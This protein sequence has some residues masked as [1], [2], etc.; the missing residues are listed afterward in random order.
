MNGGSIKEGAEEREREEFNSAGKSFFSFGTGFSPVQVVGP[1]ATRRSPKRVY[2]FLLG[3]PDGRRRVGAPEQRSLPVWAV[4]GMGLV[5]S[6]SDYVDLVLDF[7]VRAAHVSA[8][9]PTPSAVK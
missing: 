4:I 8:P 7:Y 9:P 3:Q 5:H 6:T 1:A 2:F